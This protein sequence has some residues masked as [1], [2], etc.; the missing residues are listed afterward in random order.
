MSTAKNKTFLS[1]TNK[2]YV[3]VYSEI[4]HDSGVHPGGGYWSVGPPK[5]F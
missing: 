5:K 1:T 2:N 3:N 4:A